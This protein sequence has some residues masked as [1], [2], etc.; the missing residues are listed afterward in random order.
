[1][2]IDNVYAFLVNWRLLQQSL[3]YVYIYIVLGS[4]KPDEG[5]VTRVLYHVSHYALHARARHFA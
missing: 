3:G 5:R 1:M 2:S 4:G